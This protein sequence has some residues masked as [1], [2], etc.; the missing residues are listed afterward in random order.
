MKTVISVSGS[1]IGDKNL[2]KHS[3][4]L[5]EEVGREI[6]RHGAI[7][8]CGGKGGIMEASCKGAKEE[9]GITVGILPLS[10]DEANRFVDIAIP[11]GIGNLRNF[12]VVNGADGVIALSGRWGTL[13]EISFAMIFKKP[14]V[15]MRGTG[16]IVDEIVDHRIMEKIESEY[17]ITDD[18]K[19]AVEII[20][21]KSDNL[22]HL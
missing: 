8:L 10:K 21:K 1:D 9:N 13:N 20:L 15:L 7:L 16:G 11:T 6:A 14:L 4:D 18:A 12:L 3:L 22:K 5:A 17:Y 2:S 19:E